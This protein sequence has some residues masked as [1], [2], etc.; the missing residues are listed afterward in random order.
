[1]SWEDVRINEYPS[2]II[3]IDL[4]AIASS[5]YYGLS[6]DDNWAKYHAFEGYDWNLCLVADAEYLYLVGKG[7]IYVLKNGE[8]YD[9]NIKSI[10][11]YQ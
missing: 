8:Y 6:L 11:M 3:E 2:V 1:M 4:V 5:H 10:P 7:Y 9:K